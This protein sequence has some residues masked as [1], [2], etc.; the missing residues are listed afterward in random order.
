MPAGVSLFCRRLRPPAARVAAA[1]FDRTERY[2]DIVTT[3]MLTT[4]ALHEIPVRS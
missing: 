2:A 3:L 4:S 1:I